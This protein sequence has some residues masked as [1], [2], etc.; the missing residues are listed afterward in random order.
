MPYFD[1]LFFNCQA[2]E[3]LK[4]LAFLNGGKLHVCPFHFLTGGF[5]LDFYNSVYATCARL[6]SQKTDQIR[7]SC[8]FCGWQTN[9]FSL[10]THLCF[11]DIF[12]AG[13]KKQLEE[14]GDWKIDKPEIRQSDISLLSCSYFPDHFNR[15]YEVFHT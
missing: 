5:S 7:A 11:S 4:K 2:S 10:R 13:W 15:V 14:K 8:G 9:L 1:L 6:I 12:S 3:L